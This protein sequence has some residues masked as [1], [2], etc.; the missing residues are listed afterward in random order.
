[1]G[2]DLAGGFIW[3]LSGGFNSN[4]Y[5]PL[6]TSPDFRNI[7]KPLLNLAAWDMPFRF[8]AKTFGKNLDGG[9]TQIYK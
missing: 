9:A 8:A 7:R 5:E 6:M 3:N 2:H 1:M 4:K